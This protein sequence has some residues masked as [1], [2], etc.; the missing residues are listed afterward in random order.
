MNALN[1]NNY[2]HLTRTHLMII[3][4]L[5]IL[6]YYIPFFIYWEDMFIHI[7][8]SLDSTVA[9]IKML[10]D[11]DNLFNYNATLPVMGELH[12]SSFP[13]YTILLLLNK[14]FSTFTAYFLNELAGRI[15]GFFGMYLLLTEYIIK[16]EQ[17]KNIISFV[18]A[19]SFALSGYFSIYG[20][21]M[22]G[23]PLLFYAFLNLK[24]E[25]HTWVSLLI[26]ALIVL[27]SSII[28][29]GL[30]GGFVLFIYY[31][32]IVI[33]EKR[34]HHYYLIGL[35]LFVLL[36]IAEEASLFLHFFI[37]QEPLHRV[38]FQSDSSVGNIIYEGL[39]LLYRTHYHTAS[40]PA[41][42]III[43]TIFTCIKLRK[44]EKKIKITVIFILS[45]ITFIIL[46]GVILMK[47]P[48]IKSILPPIQYDRFYFLLPTIWMVLFAL[49]LKSIIK[50]NHGKFLFL[51]FSLFFFGSI[52]FF[53][54]EYRRS[55]QRVAADTM[56]IPLTFD[57]PTFRQFYDEP[58]FNEIEK[59]L[60]NKKQYKIICLGF[61]PAIALYNGFQTLDGYFFS[62]PL[63]Y[64]H[65][66]RQIISKEL[67]K[68]DKNQ[69]YFDHWGSRCYLFSSE[70]DDDYL[71]SKNSNT[72]VT[73]LSL[74]IP[75]LKKLGGE[76]IFSSVKITNYES[77]GLRF[78][79]EFTTPNSYWSIMVYQVI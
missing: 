48:E 18:V 62:Y 66:F 42:L 3:G 4:I 44:F 45:I 24:N 59:E 36:Y 79:N 75:A 56:D 71:Y 41:F 21:S 70:L 13:N 63:E 49:C 55:I 33:K 26:I 11:S 69:K 35:I 9:S 37:N 20:F 22:I 65:K 23:Q 77:L 32:Y 40:I 68:S 12:R 16:E 38:E 29:I 17:Y 51:C 30:F 72:K 39:R 50:F 43:L 7:H 73:N 19:I 15:I 46:S 27:N 28:L 34:L 25:K 76:Y 57:E 58:L 53:N 2:M 78:V 60:G 54:K 1:Y 67:S 8:D 64:K 74:N 5:C 47:S 10:R 6:V 52:L 61:H 14:C 31:L